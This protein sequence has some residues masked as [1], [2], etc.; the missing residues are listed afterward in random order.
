MARTPGQGGR[1]QAAGGSAQ[2]QQEP[3]IAEGGASGMSGS[4]GSSQPQMNTAALQSAAAAGD[5][6]SS[7]PNAMPPPR[8]AGGEQGGITAMQSDKRVTA[9]WTINEVRNAW[10]HFDGIGWRKL[11]NN[12]DSALMALNILMSHARQTNSRVD[13]DEGSGN[14]V[15]QAY[16]W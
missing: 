16:V 3:P 7:M 1:A 10:A 11:A 5:E 14:I 8:S 6:A 12:S 15:T 13:Y 2:P 9:L 4:V